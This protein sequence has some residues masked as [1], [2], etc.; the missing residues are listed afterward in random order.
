MFGYGRRDDAVGDWGALAAGL[1]GVDAIVT[2]CLL[3]FGWNV[4]DG[5]GD[6]VVGVGDFDGGSRAV[7]GGIW[8]CEC[9]VSAD[10]AGVAK[11]LTEL[12]QVSR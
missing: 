11:G 4:V 2:D 12:A 6:E 7:A 5:G 1:V 3:A 8:F 9:L 10:G